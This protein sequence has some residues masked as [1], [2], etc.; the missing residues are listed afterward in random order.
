MDQRFQ[1]FSLIQP[2]Y[3]IK[4]KFCQF[5]FSHKLWED[6]PSV[7]T[8]QQLYSTVEVEWFN[9]WSYQTIGMIRLYLLQM[10]FYIEVDLLY[11]WVRFM[12]FSIYLLGSYSILF[13]KADLIACSSIVVHK[14][15]RY[16]APLK[17]N[18]KNYKLIPVSQNDVCLNQD[19]QISLPKILILFNFMV[20]LIQRNNKGFNTFLFLS[21]SCIA[22][23]VVNKFL[24]W[25]ILQLH[26]LIQMR[27]TPKRNVSTHFGLEWK[28]NVITYHF[29][30]QILLM[31]LSHIPNFKKEK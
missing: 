8:L 12:S 31:I 26:F 1:S 20:S 7:L 24:F 28:W 11:L 27:S 13:C 17:I 2:S 14:F 18:T 9:S 5:F 16:F 6:F 4:A 10:L 15:V 22:N 23:L 19:Q 29:V 30:I 25:K 3:F 21:H